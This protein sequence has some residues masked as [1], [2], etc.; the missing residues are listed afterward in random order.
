MCILRSYVESH[1][2]YVL[3]YIRRKKL[4]NDLCFGQYYWSAFGC[5]ISG[6]VGTP[7]S[8]NLI[9]AGEPFFNV[10]LFYLFLQFYFL[11]FGFQFFLLNNV[12]VYHV[13]VR[14]PFRLS[15]LIMIG[16]SSIFYT[17]CK[18]DLTI[19]YLQQLCAD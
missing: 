2:R 5:P 11:L 9:V 1:I 7:I 19:F 15:V 6:D 14:F 17:L 10:Q 12:V 13:F 3:V 18:K 16:V 8:P 4:I